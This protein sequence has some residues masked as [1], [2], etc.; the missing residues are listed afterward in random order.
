[1]TSQLSAAL[2]AAAAGIHP[3]E[4]AAG[5]IISHGAFLRR[6]DFTRHIETAAC[7]SDG[8]P[9]AWIDLD[10]VIAALDGS[11]LPASGGKGASSGSRPASLSTT[12]SAS[13][14]PSPASTGATWSWSPPP[15]ATPPGSASEQGPAPR[16]TY[17]EFMSGHR[18]AYLCRVHLWLFV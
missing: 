1:V 14:T 16:D 11:R 2:R 6:G 3:D 8:T 18:S 13:A 7:I 17:V 9:M 4:A 15:S 12:P 5:L 10:A